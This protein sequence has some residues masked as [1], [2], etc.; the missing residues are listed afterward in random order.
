MSD[1]TAEVET[2]SARDTV[3]LGLV[4]GALGVV[5]GDLGTSPIYTLQTVFDPADPLNVAATIWR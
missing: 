5:F 1:G 2:S 3:R 4:I